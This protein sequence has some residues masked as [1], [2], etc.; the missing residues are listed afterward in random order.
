MQKNRASH[1]A[2]LSQKA[3][4]AAPL[5][6]W[7]FL[8]ELSLSRTRN[9]A[10]LAEMRADDMMVYRTSKMSPAVHCCVGILASK[11]QSPQQDVEIFAEHN[12]ALCPAQNFYHH[13]AK[14]GQKT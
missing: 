12:C 1:A 14:K 11:L 8:L 3:V 2:V 9:N 10:K 4:G 7:T 13:W 6:I 5:I